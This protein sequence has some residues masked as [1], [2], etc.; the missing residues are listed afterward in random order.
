MSAPLKLD[1]EQLRQLAKALDALSDIT[2]ETG[3]GFASYGRFTADI[4]DSA[5]A[6]SHDGERYT[7][8]DCNGD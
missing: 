6:V 4:G 1:A 7:V 5:L 3:V 8:D 2:R